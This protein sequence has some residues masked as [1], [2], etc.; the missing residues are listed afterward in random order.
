MEADSFRKVYSQVSNRRG[1]WN[2]R[3]GGGL[4]NIW[5]TNS[6]GA[7]KHLENLI[8]GMVGISFFL[9]FFFNHKIYLLWNILYTVKYK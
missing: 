5:K 8:A 7:W 4:E 1:M 2:S 3:E 6:Q 9:S